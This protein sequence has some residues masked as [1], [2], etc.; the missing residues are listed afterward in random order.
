MNFF[1]LSNNF[2][3][4][5]RDLRTEPPLPILGADLACLDSVESTG[6]RDMCVKNRA[7]ESHFAKIVLTELLLCGLSD[8]VFNFYLYLPVLVE[9]ER[10]HNKFLSNSRF[11]KFRFPDYSQVD[12][13]ICNL[14]RSQPGTDSTTFEGWPP[15][16]LLKGF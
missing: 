6:S 10:R 11:K 7:L 16:T 12:S 1:I 14:L 8:S 3:I 2:P 4:N 9:K 5:R 15:F 13:Y